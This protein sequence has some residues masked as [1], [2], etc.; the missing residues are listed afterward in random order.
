MRYDHRNRAIVRFY[1]DDKDELEAIAR[2]FGMSSEAVK[3]VLRRAG[4]SLRRKPVQRPPNRPGQGSVDAGPPARLGPYP[5]ALAPPIDKTWCTQC[6]AL[7]RPAEIDA[8][9]SRF[10][11]AKARAA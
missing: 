8:C 4:V 6:E 7:K 3:T 10:C 11:K 5:I 1:V 2:R 9:S